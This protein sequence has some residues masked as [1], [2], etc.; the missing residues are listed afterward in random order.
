MLIEE[1][2]LNFK[3]EVDDSNLNWEKLNYNK[4]TEKKVVREDSLLSVLAIVFSFTQPI[5]GI[6]LGII[7]FMTYIDPWK[8]NRCRNAIIIGSV[9]VFIFIMMLLLQVIY[10]L[11]N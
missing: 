9:I 11:N 5:S 2:N 10:L 1:V 4:Y 3:N 7:G 8:K 6:I